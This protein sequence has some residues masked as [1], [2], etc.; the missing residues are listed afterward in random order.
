[1]A[2]SEALMISKLTGK[3]ACLFL[4]RRTAESPRVEE[5]DLYQICILYVGK[6]KETDPFYT[7]ADQ[8]Y[9]C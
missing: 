5:E 9:H 7:T 2:S 3:R 1:M 6:N 8:E 4:R